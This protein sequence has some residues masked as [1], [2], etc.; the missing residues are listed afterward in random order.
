MYHQSWGSIM[1]TILFLIEKI[2]NSITNQ[3]VCPFY[4]YG[5]YDALY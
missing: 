3:A 5:V 1:G 2:I 4:K